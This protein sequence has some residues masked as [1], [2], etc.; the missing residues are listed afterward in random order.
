MARQRVRTARIGGNQERIDELE[1]FLES[2][3]RYLFGPEGEDF[4]TLASYL[5]RTRNLSALIQL[6]RASGTKDVAEDLHMLHA[7]LETHADRSAPVVTPSY[8]V[9]AVIF[10]YRLYAD[11]LA[12]PERLLDRVQPAQRLEVVEIM[13]RGLASLAP[14]LSR[15]NAFAWLSV[16]GLPH[17]AA[18]LFS[19]TDPGI[20]IVEA[21]EAASR[22][23]ERILE[24]AKRKPRAGG[25]AY[26][27]AVLDALMEDYRS[28]LARLGASTQ[29]L[30]G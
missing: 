18:E 16:V 11:L 30:Q 24:S 25:R 27:K 15:L 17:L 10:R 3:G 13:T 9:E 7:E 21:P 26:F 23:L 2:I 4:R 28:Q 5:P 22:G 29:P 6:G 20:Q 19:D 8:R 14:A 12:H 1:Y